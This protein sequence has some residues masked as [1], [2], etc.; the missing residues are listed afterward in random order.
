MLILLYKLLFFS[1][2]FQY[3]SV[4]GDRM[5]YDMT[6]AGLEARQC[7]DLL[8]QAQ[9]HVARARRLDEEER[10]LRRKQDEERTAFKQRQIEEQVR[11]YITL[12][13][14]YRAAVNINIQSSLPLML[15]DK[16]S[17]I[18]ISTVS[19]NVSHI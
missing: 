3:L 9:Y 5:R 13:L 8:S 17:F 18:F 11:S 4:H 2:Y 12:Y 15:Y 1:R 6:L 19:N 7:Q 14:L 10:Q 16:L